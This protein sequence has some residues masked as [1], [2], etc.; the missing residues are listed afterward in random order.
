MHTEENNWR[1]GRNILMGKYLQGVIRDI[2]K[3]YAR[4]IV[5]SGITLENN[6][7]RK[8]ILVN[9]RVGR[10]TILELTNIRAGKLAGEMIN[11]YNPRKKT[12]NLQGRY[13]NR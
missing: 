5:C 10:K 13:S 1:F 6:L 11:M 7:E 4:E 2:E 9:R 3:L 12:K 8:N